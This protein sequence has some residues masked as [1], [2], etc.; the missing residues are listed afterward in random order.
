MK[1]KKI[2]IYLQSVWGI[3]LIAGCAQQGSPTGGPIDEDPPVVLKTI[4][5][6]YSTNFEDDQITIEFNEY[7]DM[8]NFTQELVV[9]PP[10]EEKPEI[11]LKNKM[12]IIDI[13][14]GL[15]DDVTYT[16]NFG[17]GIK[18]L[19]EGNVLLNYEYVFAT[20]DLLDSLSVK[21]TLRNAFD[22]SV[23]EMPVDIMLYNALEDS[24]PLTQ[25]PYYVG[26]ADDKGNFEV[27]NLRKGIYKMFVLK[28][29]NNNFLFDLPNEPIAFL[30][31]S[32]L[33]DGDFFRQILQ[34]SGT[35]DS[36][37]LF[38][39]TL[40]LEADTTGMSADSIAMLL[41]SLEQMKPDLNSIYLDLFM[42]EEDP[43]Q[44]FISDY[45]R[46]RREALTLLFNI[47]LTDSFAFNP[48]YPPLLMPED[49]IPEYGLKRDSLVLWMADTVVA[50]YD[51]IGIMLKYT[52]LDSLDNP[53]VKQDT[54]EFVFRAKKEKT[55]AVE[56]GP[57]PLRVT[58][59]RK[60]AKH[61]I[62]KDILFNLEEPLDRIDPAMFNLFIIPDSVE[63]PVEAEV[64]KDTT[65]LRRA[66]MRHAWKEEGSY[67]MVIYPGGISSVYG[68]MNDTID[69]SFKIRPLAEYGRIL[70]SLE[71][72]TDTVQIQLF[73]KKKI[74]RE[75]RVTE[76]G[77]VVFD[78]LDPSTYQI[79][80]IHDRN[81]NGE[82][83]TGKYIEGLQPERVEF[84]PSAV[85]VR[86]NWDHEV[87]Y[88]MGTHHG[89]PL[90]AE[91]TEPSF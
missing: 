51:T 67:R 83:D 26:R 57:E 45:E 42:F 50:A 88:R 75:K 77:Q 79:K 56:K 29:G 33:V 91:E 22:L 76:P 6:N 58:T 78:F 4:P 21:G 27:N 23:P 32:L 54:V 70:L 10:T 3:V 65:H 24:L 5:E 35:Y 41:D 15:K 36:T 64:F 7:L 12:L 20:G 47:P 66:R 30:D 60:G 62:K 49:L 25:I 59:I 44:Q 87:N 9:S 31:T 38:S 82:W 52:V 14:E 28:D 81:G 34:E 86:A 53:L 71:N 1:L 73:S 18:D 43:V 37:D 89:P 69:I 48:I 68:A 40:V 39:D 84:V 13:E 61:H 72:V 46:A 2:I 17:E 90:E 55:K 19:N 11:R 80:F 85:N 8:A 74:V 16:F 63:V